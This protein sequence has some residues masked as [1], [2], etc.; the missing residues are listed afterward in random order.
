MRSFTRKPLIP[1]NAAKLAIKSQT[2]KYLPVFYK[3]CNKFRIKRPKIRRRQPS[4]TQKATFYAPKDRL[5]PTK[6][7]PFTTQNT[8]FCNTLATSTLHNHTKTARP[9]PPYG[10]KTAAETPPR[11][12]TRITHA[13][14]KPA[15]NRQPARNYLEMRKKQTRRARFLRKEL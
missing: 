3:K 15:R 8:V 7:P 4:A 2:C 14:P 9:A 5:S 1:L 6:R 11:R 10:P 12:Q 13:Q